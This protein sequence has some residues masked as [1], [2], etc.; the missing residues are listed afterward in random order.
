MDLLLEFANQHHPL[1]GLDERLGLQAAGT[2]QAVTGVDRLIQL[3]DRPRGLH[4]PLSPACKRLRP[5][6]GQ[7]VAHRFQTGP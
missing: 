2:L 5:P 7:R 3:S 4:A 1:E 6:R